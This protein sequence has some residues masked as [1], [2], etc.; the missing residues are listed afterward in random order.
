MPFGRRVARTGRG[1]P[2]AARWFARGIV[3]VPF[4]PGAFALVDALSVAECHQLLHQAQAKGFTP[5]ELTNAHQFTWLVGPAL[6]L[7]L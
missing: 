6:L 5:D 7:V 4:V 2:P 3:E 1:Q